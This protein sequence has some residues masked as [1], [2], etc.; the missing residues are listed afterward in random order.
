MKEGKVIKIMRG[1]RK[2]LVGVVQSVREELALFQ[3]CGFS[4]SDLHVCVFWHHCLAE[5]FG[6]QRLQSVPCHYQV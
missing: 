6:S 2:E 4:S 3:R 5:A 1:Q